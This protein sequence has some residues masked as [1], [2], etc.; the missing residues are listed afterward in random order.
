M[1]TLYLTFILLLTSVFTYG[2]NSIAKIKYGQAEEAFAKGNYQEA[3]GYLEETEKILKS[4]NTT[5]TYLKILCQKNLLDANPMGSFDLI[6]SLRKNCE[7]YLKAADGKPD[8]EDKFK[9]VYFISQELQ[10][11]PKTREEFD[12]ELQRIEQERL[13]QE[14]LRKEEQE[15]QRKLAEEARLKAEEEAR[16][17]R[18]R[19]FRNISYGCF[20]FG[21]SLPLSAD[22]RDNITYNQW[23]SNTNQTPFTTA[24]IAGKVGLKMGLSLGFGGVIGVDKLTSKFKN[25]RLGFGWNWDINQNF[26]FYKLDI[27]GFPQSQSWYVEEISRAPFATTSLGIGPNL[28]VRVGSQKTLIDMYFRADANLFWLGK[29]EATTYDSN[30][31]TV[32]A[33]GYRSNKDKSISPTIGFALRKNNMKLGLEFRLKLIDESKYYDDFSYYYGSYNNTYVYSTKDIN[34][35]Y[36]S[37]NYGFVF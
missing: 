17:R 11:L 30:S 13:E 37:L 14:R 28:S 31:G 24:M 21:L 36:I 4:A 22:S 18:E 35:S 8:L 5:T 6:A 16:I 23:A 34:L 7:F 2:Q 29:Y 33:K 19:E 9:E 1:K 20:K 3:L 15:R 26:Q 12:A 10:K 27:A 25:D 32:E